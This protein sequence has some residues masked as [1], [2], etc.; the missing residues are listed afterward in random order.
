ME[1]LI[2]PIALLA[3]GDEITEG[4][5]LNTNTPFIAKQLRQHDFQVGQ[6]MSIA[7]NQ[8]TIAEAIRYLLTQHVGLI[9]TGGLGPTS[10]DR[11]RFALSDAV[12]KELKFDEASWQHIQTRLQRLNIPIPENNRQQCFFPVG[13]II[14]KNLHGT[15]NGCALD[16]TSHIIFMLPGPPNE[17]RILFETDVLPHIKQRIQ[18]RP[19]Y[20]QHFLLLGMGEGNLADEVDPLMAKFPD[21]QVGYRVCFPYIELKLLSSNQFSLNKLIQSTKSIITP[22]LISKQNQTASEQ[23][24]QWIIHH[25]TTF[26]FDDQ[27]TYGKF[28][29]KLLNIQTISKFHFT[30]MP[31]A[32]IQIQLHGLSE[33]WQQLTTQQ[34]QIHVSGTHHG[35]SFSHS[36]TLGNRGDRTLDAAIE[37]I[38]WYLFKLL[39]SNT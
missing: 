27:A 2:G 6:H 39:R 7:D 23:L 31:T 11:T 34:T 32:D 3:T 15:A 36:M 12:N 9:M 18:S 35:K 37:W 29:N 5:V 28:L 26:Y 38:S 1:G 24:Q 17:C 30:S 8:E 19:I 16:L 25:N 20:R 22:Y 4:D 33:V 10:D 21:C 13:G 14:L